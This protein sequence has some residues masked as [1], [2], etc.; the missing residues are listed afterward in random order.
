[1]SGAGVLYSEV[2]CSGGR[3]AVQSGPMHPGTSFPCV[4]RRAVNI[5][6]KNS[7]YIPTQFLFAKVRPQVY[8]CC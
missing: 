4:N 3:K 7:C 6:M 8:T 1:M 2:S 5:A